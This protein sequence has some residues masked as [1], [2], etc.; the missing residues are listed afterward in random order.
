M[1]PLPV[2]TAAPAARRPSRIPYAAGVGTKAPTTAATAAL[3]RLG[4]EHVPHPFEHVGGERSY[5]L[6]A[7]AALGV[8][9]ERVFKTLVVTAGGRLAVAI[10]PVSGELDL[11][12]VAAALDTKRAALADP[13]TAERRTG[14]VVGGISP[15]G[16]R[17]RLPTLLDTSAGEHATVFVSGGRRGFDIEL[18]PADL[19]RATDARLV[20]IAR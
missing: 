1:P 10:T 20:A 5:G 7:A 4:I 18:A 3:I 15:I 11:R 14:Y 2:L 19:Q 13:T 8:P 9:A 12:A 17:E 6:E 16:Q